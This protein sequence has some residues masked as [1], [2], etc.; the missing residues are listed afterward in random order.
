MYQ[1][2]VHA[3]GDQ[4]NAYR[5][6]HLPFKGEFEFGAHTVGPAD[7]NG[8]FIAF[9]HFEQGAK[10]TNTR[11]YAFAHG[12]FG[13]GLDAFDQGIA[14]VDVNACVF[15]GKGVVHGALWGW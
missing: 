3:H 15:I 2:V 5:V 8:L 7:Q 1:H 13:Q 14:S 12:F 9:W 11:Q 10:T 4:V 6:V